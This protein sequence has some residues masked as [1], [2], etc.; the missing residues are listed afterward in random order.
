M[1]KQFIL[2]MAFLVICLLATTSVVVSNTRTCKLEQKEAKPNSPNDFLL[3]GTL[4]YF[5]L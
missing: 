4:N 5:Q 1:K 2:L 3:P